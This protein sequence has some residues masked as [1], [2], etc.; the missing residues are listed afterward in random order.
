MR[1][2]ITKSCEYQK[3]IEYE[4]EN[5]DE[6]M[7]IIREKNSPFNEGQ[8]DRTVTVSEIELLSSNNSSMFSSN[9]T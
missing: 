2:E 5:R 7:I 4:R 3:I 1:I 8:A 9:C 6:I